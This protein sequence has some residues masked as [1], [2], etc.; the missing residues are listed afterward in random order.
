MMRESFSRQYIHISIH[1]TG[2]STT[3]IHQTFC[4]AHNQSQKRK[5]THFLLFNTHSI[6]I[7]LFIKNP[8]QTSVANRIGTR[9]FQNKPS[10]ILKRR[11]LQ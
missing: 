7:P 3:E 9:C 4:S 11:K 8:C 6:S 10:L 1:L 5:K 2:N